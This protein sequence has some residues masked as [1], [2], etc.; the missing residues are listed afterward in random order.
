MELGPAEIAGLQYLLKSGR[1]ESAMDA[2]VKSLDPAMHWGE[3]FSQA[4]V[5]SIARETLRH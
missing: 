3:G 5:A 1:L 2:A 4:T